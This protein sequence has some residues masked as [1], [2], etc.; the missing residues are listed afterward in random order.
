M[1]KVFIQESTLTDIANAIRTCKAKFIP[2][3]KISKTPNA[4]GPDTCNNLYWWGNDGSM[5]P[6]GYLESVTISGAV[7]LKVKLN[8]QTV[9]RD[10]AQINSIQV[11]AGVLTRDEMHASTATKEYISTTIRTVNLTFNSDSV[12]F[13]A[14][15]TQ[16]DKDR[17]DGYLGYYAEVTGYDADGNIIGTYEYN[18]DLID[19]ADFAAEILAIGGNN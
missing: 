4:T 19:P 11:A 13:W 14:R 10:I 6:I 15:S 2:T 1:A 8:Y 18:T 17:T 9:P 7:S 12:T 3:I 16:S 5:L